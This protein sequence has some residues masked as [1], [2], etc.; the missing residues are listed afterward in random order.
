MSLQPDSPPSLTP[1]LWVPTAQRFPPTP[2]SYPEEEHVRCL[3]VRRG[4]VVILEWNSQHYCWDDANGDD[5]F[6][7]LLDVSHWMPVP[8]MPLPA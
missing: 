1:S 5:F 2:D 4:E 7:N 8:A 3:C 6:C